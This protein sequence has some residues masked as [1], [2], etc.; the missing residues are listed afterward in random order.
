MLKIKHSRISAI[1][2]MLFC[3][4][5]LSGYILDFTT[6]Y[7]SLLAEFQQDL[8]P[9]FGNLA[10]WGGILG[11]LGVLCFLGN[12]LISNKDV[13]TMDA[14]EIKFHAPL[15][16][17]NMTLQWKEIEKIQLGYQ[18]VP[19]GDIKYLVITPLNEEAAKK[20]NRVNKKAEEHIPIGL[21]WDTKKRIGIPVDGLSLKS[22]EILVQAKRFLAENS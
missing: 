18:N 8:G 1:G 3:L 10:Y 22:K 19:Y 4:F 6:D 17:N 12:Q 2:W 20:Y 16:I 5:L 7:R 13:I 9:L 15:K 14:N 21:S 11:L